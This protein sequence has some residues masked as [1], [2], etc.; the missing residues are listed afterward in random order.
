MQTLIKIHDLVKTFEIGSERI[1]ALN[2][3]SL[4][5]E[6]GEFLAI[7]GTSGCGKSTLMYILGL[8]DIQTSGE[9]L[10]RG[11]T[12][13][14]LSENQ[15]AQMRNQLIGF[16]FQSFHL[17]PRANALRNVA[18]P[19]VYS[20]SYGSV[21]AHDEIEERAR[22]ALIRVGLE[23]R[24]LHKPNE[25]SG[26]Q[27]QRVAIARAIVNKP[28]LILADEPTGNLDSHKGKEILDIFEELNSEGVTVALVTHDESVADRAKRVVELKDG[29]ITSDS[30]KETSNALA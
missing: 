6:E 3:I 28:K 26:G 4:T 25:L 11:E 23:D 16:V 22:Q 24:M 8:L 18:M 15:R 29:C 27:R 9:Y 12:T 21:L 5:I 30:K 19:L 7:K 13:S 20:S 10:L 17:L 1:N 14:R 2:K